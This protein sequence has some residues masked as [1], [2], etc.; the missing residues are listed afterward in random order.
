[1]AKT[2]I[3]KPISKSQS[4]I[5]DLDLD[6]ETSAEGPVKSETVSKPPKQ[7]V[8]N[9]TGK[10]EVMTDLFKL[11][12]AEFFK[13]D[14]YQEEIEHPETHPQNFLRTEH[15]HYFRTYDKG[16]RKQTMS[17]PV[18]G[19]FHLVEWDEDPQGGEPHIKSVSGPMVMG[20]IKNRGR[21][22]RGPVPKNDYD[23]HT[24]GVEYVKSSAIQFTP[25]NVEAQIVITREQMKTAPIPGVKS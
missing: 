15:V 17:V 10:K 16:G 18:G 6:L 24:H 13:Y 23:F 9:L 2:T 12:V 22:T 5:D 11:S 7:F 4:N 3:K 20:T 14:S 8:R 1:M 19:H 21:I 25:T